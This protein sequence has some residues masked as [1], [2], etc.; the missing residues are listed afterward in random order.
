MVRGLLTCERLKRLVYVSCNPDSMT[1]NVAQLCCPPSAGGCLSEGIPSLQPGSPPLLATRSKIWALG[2]LYAPLHA[3]VLSR[4][5]GVAA[6][7][8]VR[9]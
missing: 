8:R 4:T 9:A 2:R 3:P 1:E 5:V 7:L 6:T